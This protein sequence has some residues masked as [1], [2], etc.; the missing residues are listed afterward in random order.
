MSGVGIHSITFF[1]PDKSTQSYI[2]SDGT[3]RYERNRNGA[4]F[5]FNVSLTRDRAVTVRVAVFDHERS[6]NELERDAYEQVK[7]ILIALGKIGEGLEIPKLGD[8]N[9]TPKLGNENKIA[10]A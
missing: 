6:L 3:F 10:A 7:R 5:V 9:E 4:E 2:D 1:G 8:A